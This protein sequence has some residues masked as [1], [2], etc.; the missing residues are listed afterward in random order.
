MPNN[1]YDSIIIGS[2]A[3]GLTAATALANAGQKVLVCEQHGKPGGWTH[4]FTLEGHSF[5]PGVHY[6]GGLNPGEYLD[7]IF[8]GL[9]VSGNLDFVE[10]NPNGFDH[11]FIGDR[12]FDI[13]KGKDNYIKR[14]IETFP[15]EEKGIRKLFKVID[16]IGTFMSS[17][18]RG[19]IPFTK[20]GTMRWIWKSGGSLVYRYVNDPVLRAILLSQAGDYGLPP[21]NT[22]A[23][24]HVGIMRHYLNGGFYPVGGAISIPKAFIK[25]LKNN[26]SE[27]KLKTLVTK[28]I[29]ENKKVVGV[30]TANG[31]MFFADNIVSNTDPQN[32]FINLIGKKHLSKKLS[33]KLSKTKYST[34]CISLFLAVKMDLKKMGFDSGNYWFYDNSDIDKI[35]SLS[36]SDYIINNPPPAAFMTITTL[37]DPSKMKNGTHTIEAFFFTEYESFKKWE[38]EPK[39]NRSTDYNT[40][41]EKIMENIIEFLDQRVPSLKKSIVYKNLSTPLTVKHYINSYKGNIYGT[42][43]IIKQIGPFGYRTKTEIENLYLCGASTFSHGVAGVIGTGLKAAAS[44][45]KCKT[46]DLLNQ[47]GPKLKIIPSEAMHG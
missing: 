33:K 25:T 23:F 34:S 12:K 45:L 46:N 19:K 4:S 14:L 10:L 32:T 15:K 38:N 44:I 5:S 35:Y 2:G 6:I 36:H 17:A 16:N 40:L 1:K 11:V 9:G 29:C 37:K 42:D 18:G 3:G 41:K 28:I 24:V 7:R 30:K 47:N 20:L 13:P 26:G 43:K 31:E 8:R 21:S 39:G 22:S 27:L